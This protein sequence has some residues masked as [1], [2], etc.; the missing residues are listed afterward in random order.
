MC[1][2]TNPVLNIH[3]NTDSSECYD[4]VR[5][6]DE[7]LALNTVVANLELEIQWLE[8]KIKRY[9]FILKGGVL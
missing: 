8:D 9:E 7:I 6:A 3:S 2:K 1:I 4:K 5:L